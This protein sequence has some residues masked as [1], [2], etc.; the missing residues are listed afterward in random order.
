MIRRFGYSSKL[1]AAASIKI[2][3]AL[4]GAALQQSS[5]IQ[6]HRGIRRNRAA[7]GGSNK[8]TGI[9]ETQDR[10]QVRAL[11]QPLPQV[12][13][14]IPPAQ[15]AGELQRRFQLQGQDCCIFRIAHELCQQS[16]DIRKSGKF[17]WTGRVCRSLNGSMSLGYGLHERGCARGHWKKHGKKTRLAARTAEHPLVFYNI[18]TLHAL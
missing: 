15:C 12:L 18:Y 4:G 6:M 10:A 1:I 13:G 17:L 5:I 9:F 16:I 8:E 11:L 14:L 7:A 3:N 2:V